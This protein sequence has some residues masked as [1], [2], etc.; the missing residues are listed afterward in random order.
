VDR[1]SKMG[2]FN[3]FNKVPSTTETAFAFMKEIFRLYGLPHE[4]ISDRGTQFTSKF[5]NA[6]YKIFHI[7]LKFSSLF[8]HQTNSLTERV[9]SVVEQYLRCFVNYKGNNWSNYL[10]L[11][12]FSY[13]NAVQ[14][15]LKY[16]PFYANYG[17]KTRY[18]PAF[19]V[20][21]MFLVQMNLLKNF[22]G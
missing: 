16:S 1:F 22:L 18:S 17:Y 6:I 15:S 20:I 8:H 14:E 4:I 3:P 10:Y 19:Q 2:H 7:D 5:W 12:E 9:S 11:S 13:N 21:L